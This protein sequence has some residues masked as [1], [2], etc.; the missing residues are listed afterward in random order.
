MEGEVVDLWKVVVVGIGICFMEGIELDDW[1]VV[2]C[3]CVLG[4]CWV[5]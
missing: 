2:V 3:Y 1:I 5:D 4:D